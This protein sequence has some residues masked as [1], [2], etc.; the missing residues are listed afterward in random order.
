VKL[1]NALGCRVFLNLMRTRLNLSTR[2]F[3]NHRLFLIAVVVV[4]FMSLWLMLSFANEKSSVVARADD[5]K[6]RI[7]S[8]KQLA[9][10]AANELERRKKEQVKVVL[11]E[12]QQVE[13]AAARQLIG[14]KVFSWNKILSDIEEYVP[15]NT[16][17][18]SIKVEE[19][20]NSGEDAMA[21]V[22]VKA[23]GTTSNEM[24]E[25]MISLEKSN[26]L[27]TVGETGQE[28]IT[29][30]GETPFTLNLTYR[31]HKGDAQ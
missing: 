11:T 2:P 26:G 3:T 21:S 4:Y 17:I 31:P 19:V 7:D 12:H 20:A 18:I 1:A 29:D 23:I 8:Q 22:Q 25:M 24:T 10:E 5:T 28:A 6:R 15:K 27:F 14:R 9:Q 16:R 13:L 30:N